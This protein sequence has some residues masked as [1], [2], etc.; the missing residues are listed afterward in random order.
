[1]LALAAS[2]GFAL[3]GVAVHLLAILVVTIGLLICVT[4]CWY[5]VSRRGLVR[6]I[7]L[8]VVA[9]ALGGTITGLFFAG[10]RWLLVVLIAGAPTRLCGRTRPGWPGPGRRS[11]RC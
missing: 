6:M 10:I 8:L 9:A 4:G 7:S 2:A 1:L 5:A 11:T 3:V